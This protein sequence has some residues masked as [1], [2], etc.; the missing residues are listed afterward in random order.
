MIDRGRV[1]K[2]LMGAVAIIGLALPVWAGECGVLC[3]AAFYETA[4]PASLQQVIDTGAD[5]NA[6][7]DVGRSALHW[8]AGAAPEV[9]VSLLQAGADVHAGD[10]YQRTPLHFVS[11]TGSGENIT[12]LLQAGAD[13]NARTANDWTPLHGVAKFGAPENV[14]LLLAAGAD[15]AARTQMGETAFVLGETNARMAG[16]EALEVLRAA[17]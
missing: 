3:D 11:A 4:N 6:R 1:M 10:Q 5:V 14:T 7:D 16:T 17:Q 12:L 15:G 2:S 13:V 9:I 8:A